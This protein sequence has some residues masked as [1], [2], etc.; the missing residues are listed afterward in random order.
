[1]TINEHDLLV[2]RVVGLLIYHDVLFEMVI[3]DGR[4]T[5]R[6]R[7]CVDPLLSEQWAVIQVLPPDDVGV[8]LDCGHP[9]ANHADR[10]CDTCTMCS[11]QRMAQR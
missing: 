7:V 2:G 5:D 11:A 1:M 9:W 10:R 3:E 8:C 4:Y 6:I